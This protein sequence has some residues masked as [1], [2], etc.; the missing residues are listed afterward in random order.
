MR[1]QSLFLL[2]AQFLLALVLSATAGCRRDSSAGSDKSSAAD[3]THAG[4]PAPTNRIDIP[5]TV[6]RNLGI[7]FAKVENRPV[8]QTIR[9][10]GQFE[11]QP[12][13]RR[14]YRTML[15]GR[16]ELRV[17]QFDPIQ[18]GT[19]LYRLV[20]PDWRE[21]QS[22]LIEAES[23]IRQ[24]EARVASVPMLLEAHK[25]HEESLKTTVALWEK[26]VEQLD[27]TRTSGVVTAEEFTVAQNT[28]AMQRA[29]LAE[30]VEKEA[31][32]QAAGMETQ[33]LHDAA[34]ARFRLLLS[35]AA[36]LLGMEERQLSA[37]Y[38]PDE[39]WLTGLHHHGTPSS[40][41]LPAWHSINEIEVRATAPGVVQSLDLTNGAWASAGSLV[42]ST[43]E[44]E[45]LRFRAM[46]L[47]SDLTRLRDGL[48]A[49]IVPPKGGSVQLQDAMETALKVGLVA[50]P[51]E[52]TVELI[53]V[54]SKL[55]A[56][57]RPGVSAHLEVAVAGGESELAIPL[58]SVIQDG[59]AKIIFRRDPKDADR[60]IRMDA[61]LGV[62][63]GRWVAIRSGVREGDE[64]V[65]DGVYQLMIASSGSVEKGGH[66]HSDG[67]FHAG[68]DEK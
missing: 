27:Q 26:R 47:Q 30:V 1:F 67:T 13:A 62:N 66:F 44:P 29:A 8:A 17:R 41:P 37:P 14:E 51:Q 4:D 45:R 11:L 35:T 25:K 15:S 20:S 48:P 10:P 43:I 53:G 6:R 36:T 59:L 49:K 42:L 65:L 56:W 34:H 68:K 22:K 54:P 38:E 52:R 39:H 24:A 63:D 3:E 21:L 18:P 32:L 40:Q 9:V 58:S 2:L 50:D 31:E 23:S 19:S 28:L 46:G 60:V 61:D 7:T 64:V 5:E 12:E 33:A 55:S 16:V 57:A